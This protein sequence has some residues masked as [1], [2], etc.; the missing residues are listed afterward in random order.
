MATKKF[1][2]YN[3]QLLRSMLRNK[4]SNKKNGQKK[5]QE[6]DPARQKIHRPHPADRTRT[7]TQMERKTTSGCEKDQGRVGD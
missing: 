2:K 4:V 3:F 7:G 6:I 5:H 1:G